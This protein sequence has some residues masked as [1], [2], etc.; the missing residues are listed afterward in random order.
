MQGAAEELLHMA[1]AR[2]V[3]DGNPDAIERW[4]KDGR[5]KELTDAEKS[6]DS[7]EEG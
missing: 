4:I 3:G 6:R 7:R 1:K 5:W 2:A